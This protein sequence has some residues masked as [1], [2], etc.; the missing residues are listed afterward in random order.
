MGSYKQAVLALAGAQASNYAVTPFTTSALNYTVTA[1]PVQAVTS[2]SAG[3]F[4]A[5]A[6]NS[7]PARN[8]APINSQVNLVSMPL[9]ATQAA[10]SASSSVTQATGVGP[11]E[12]THAEVPTAQAFDQ[13]MP[14]ARSADAGSTGAGAVKIALHAIAIKEP[15]L[16]SGFTAQDMD[17]APLDMN[18]DV[19][20]GTVNAQMPSQAQTS[21]AWVA[22]EDTTLED[23]VYAV[24]R[25]VLQS[26]TTYQVL[27]GASSVVFL[28]KTLAPS[29]LS[30]FQWPGN[31]P[32]PAP[33]RVPV[34]SGPVS[35]GRTAVRW[36]G[37]V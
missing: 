31:L 20:Q 8:A 36:L 25:E 11:G 6:M 9:A 28:V 13:P 5:A 24:V 33:V 21:Q 37:R 15:A 32:G 23:Q 22:T 26:P 29:L 34:P 17:F 4:V 7:L 18:S 3:S 2:V 10:T 1:I 35:A 30:G 14:L 16:V 12:L 19:T 27:T